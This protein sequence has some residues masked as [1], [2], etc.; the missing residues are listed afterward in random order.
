MSKETYFYLF[1]LKLSQMS[2]ATDTWVTANMLMSR[3]ALREV[4]KTINKSYKYR[5]DPRA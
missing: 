1:C 2:R 5:F 3:S 4:Y